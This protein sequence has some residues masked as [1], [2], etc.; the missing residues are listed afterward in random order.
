VRNRTL[1]PTNIEIHTQGYTKGEWGGVFWE[2]KKR[3]PTQNLPN[4]KG[5]CNKGDGEGE[6]RGGG[7]AVEKGHGLIYENGGNNAL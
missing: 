3:N 6:K 1:K 5:E 7:V 2:S 4:I